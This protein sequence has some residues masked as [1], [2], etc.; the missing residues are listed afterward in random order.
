L[1]ALICLATGIFLL[2][3]GMSFRSIIIA[4]IRSLH[5][6]CWLLTFLGFARRY[7]TRPNSF[8]KYANR[9]V[10]PFYILHQTMIVAIGFFLMKWNAILPLKWITLAVLSFTF[11]MVPYEFFIRRFRLFRILFGMKG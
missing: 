7:L 5:T 3:S 11:I 1:L 2:E 10:L 9:A 4:P 6:W 8:L